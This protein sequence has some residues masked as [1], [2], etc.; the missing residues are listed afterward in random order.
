MGAVAIV[1]DLSGP[2]GIVPDLTKRIEKVVRDALRFI[3]T[4]LTVIVFG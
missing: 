3:S 2:A 4:I 1:S